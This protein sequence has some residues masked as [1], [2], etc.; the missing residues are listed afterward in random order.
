MNDPRNITIALL[1]VSAAVRD[2]HARRSG[3]P[4]WRYG[5]IHNGVDPDDYAADL[6]RGRQLRSGW[7]VGDEEVLLA[8]VGRLDYQKNVAVFLAAAGRL[9]RAGKGVR[10]VIAGD[11]PERPLVEEF[12]RRDDAS[13]WAVWLGFTDDVAGV[14]SAADVLV[15]PSRWEGF[16]LAAAEAM[17]AGLP[18]VATRVPGL[19]EVIE[20]GES[21]LLV[22]SEDL[23]G[24][25]AAVARLVDDPATRARLGLA[26]RRRVGERFSIAANVAAHER[27]YTEL[28]GGAP[29]RVS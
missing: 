25:A 15:L 24:L 20:D 8:F 1:C 5:V 18:V 7:G 27:L 2:H 6:A 19:T 26:G 28:A 4:A 16:G 22:D 13:R 29:A 3:L 12:L 14:L 23:D 9:R 21:G 17:A 11:G 10:G